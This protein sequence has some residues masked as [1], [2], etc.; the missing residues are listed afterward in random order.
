VGGAAR[1]GG[2]AAEGGWGDRPLGFGSR[3][4]EKRNISSDYHVGERY[5]VKY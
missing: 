4:S 1:Q 2:G 5:D 3:G